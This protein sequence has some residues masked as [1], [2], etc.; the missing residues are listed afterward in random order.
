MNIIRTLWGNGNSEG[1][2]VREIAARKIDP[3]LTIVFCLGK[4]NCQTV[5]DYGYRAVLVDANPRIFDKQ[6]Q[7]RNRLFLLNAAGNLLGGSI[8]SLDWD[9]FPIQPLPADF[10]ERF[11]RYDRY[12]ASLDRPPQVKQRLRRRN[13]SIAKGEQM[14]QGAFQFFADPMVIS[15]M[16]ALWEKTPNCFNDE[17]IARHWLTARHG[18][19]PDPNTYWQKH[20]PWC[21]SSGRAYRIFGRWKMRE[22]QHLFIHQHL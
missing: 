1:R 19:W 14:P 13:P 2:L 5:E 22:K 11:A 10:P 18:S 3:L 17:T 20:E 4:E 7:Y 21:Y 9:C 16:F 6:E 12:A 8:L 15:E